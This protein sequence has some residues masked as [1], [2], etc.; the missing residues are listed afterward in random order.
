MAEQKTLPMLGAP[1]LL[2]NA[3]AD[4]AWQRQYSAGAMR[5]ARDQLH[6]TNPARKATRARE[7]CC[8]LEKECRRRSRKEIKGP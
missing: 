6:P 4:E 8:P 2:P 1:G 3:Y 5:Q 7:V